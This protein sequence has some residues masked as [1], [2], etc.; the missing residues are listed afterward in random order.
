LS[1]FLGNTGSLEPTLSPI[2]YVSILQI[3]FLVD[4]VVSAISDFG[5]QL[6]I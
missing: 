6:D 1:C 5:E 3:F 4:L 2:L